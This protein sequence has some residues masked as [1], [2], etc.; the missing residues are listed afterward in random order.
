MSATYSYRPNGMLDAGTELNVIQRE[1]RESLGKLNGA[2][3]TFRQ[4]NQSDAVD[5]YTAE[6]QKW[7]EGLEKM[8]HGL[9]SAQMR[10]ENILAN[11]QLAQ[12]RGVGLFG[13]QV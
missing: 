13:G 9:A 2:V 3:L 8:E 7:N 12:N 4:A 1:L 5:A 6:Q 10:L 11:Y